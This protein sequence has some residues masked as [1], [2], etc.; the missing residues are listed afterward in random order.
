[1]TEFERATLSQHHGNTK[2]A[3]QDTL[4]VHILIGPH[5][6]RYTNN[7]THA[8]PPL[9]EQ[10]SLYSIIILFAIR[11]SPFIA[12]RTK[13]RPGFVRKRTREQMRKQA[14]DAEAGT[15]RGTS[16]D[17]MRAPEATKE[18]DPRRIR[19]C[20]VFQLALV[21]LDA[22][23][24]QL[25]RGLTLRN[26]GLTCVQHKHTRSTTA[27]RALAFETSPAGQKI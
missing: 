3:P 2:S 23:S 14:H 26:A 15:E 7:L 4:N 21:T 9:H 5:A 22:G 24:M 20:G 17:I 27:A 16:P 6:E 11:Y 10:P 18:C 8:H 1:M 25:G 13:G 19:V 12:L